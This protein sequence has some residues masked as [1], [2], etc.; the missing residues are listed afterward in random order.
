MNGFGTSN[1]YLRKDIGRIAGSKKLPRAFLYFM[2]ISCH[3]LN[4]SLA[5]R[6]S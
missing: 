3:F 2:A 1:V 6:I 5:S 4:K